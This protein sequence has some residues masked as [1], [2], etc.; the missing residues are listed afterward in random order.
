MESYEDFLQDM[1]R[2]RF[3]RRSGRLLLAQLSMGARIRSV[4]SL[5]FDNGVTWCHIARAD[6]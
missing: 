6:F 5:C 4:A 1:G 2:K 3:A